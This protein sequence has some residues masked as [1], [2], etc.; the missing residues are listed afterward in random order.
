MSTSSINSV[1]ALIGT[2]GFLGVMIA[3]PWVP[4]LCIVLLSLRFSAVEAVL[5]GFLMDMMWL[6]EV[7]PHGLPLYTIASIIIVWGLEP[8]RLEFLR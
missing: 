4:M 3:P 6:P 5:L 7:F 8:L 1:R 2:V